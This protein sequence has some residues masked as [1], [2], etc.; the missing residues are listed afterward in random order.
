MAQ[1]SNPNSLPGIVTDQPE[2][3]ES[4]PTLSDDTGVNDLDLTTEPTDEAIALIEV[5]IRQ[6]FSYF[7]ER[8]NEIAKF[9]VQRHG[10]Y[11]ISGGKPDEET[12]I[13][14]YHRLVSEVNQLLNK[15][16]AERASKLNKDGM[17][18]IGSLDSASLTNNLE[19]L[20][21]QLK[22]LEF[23]AEDGSLNPTQSEF[24]D[25]KSKLDKLGERVISGDGEGPI[26][27]KEARPIET[28]KLIRMNALERRLNLLET[29]LG[30]NE[31]KA[32]ALLKT[33]KC[34]SLTEAAET[35][36]SWL[37][38]YKSD[39]VDRVSKELDFLS[40]RLE[41]LNDQTVSGETGK[42]ELDPQVKVKL[43]QLCNMV[44]TTDKYRAM[45]PTIIHRLNAMEELQQ[46]AAQ[47]ATT[48]N[49]LELVQSQIVDSLQTNRDELTSLNEMFAKNIELFKEFSNDI[50]T[51]IASIR[52][53]DQ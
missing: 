33:T 29:L 15:F 4:E 27:S 10:E 38:L 18:A 52:N 22:T 39:N 35:L 25:I 12:D 45:V 16:Q 5:P 43:D 21:R 6:A 14:K 17:S 20:A 31:S 49:H 19:I 7:A 32:E 24:I 48:V 11:K 53:K 28:A 1:V 41:K 50:D 9:Y 40:Q 2:I 13:E 47:V 26:D 46:K 51:R 34:E 36:S 8:E 37:S 30:H 42:Q 3:F 44:T 23:A